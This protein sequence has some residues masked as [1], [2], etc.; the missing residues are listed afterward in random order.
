MKRKSEALAELGVVA[1][2][3]GSDAHLR[4]TTK[5][6]LDDIEIELK[7]LLLVHEQREAVISMRS[8][9]VFAA[10]GAEMANQ[11]F[12]KMLELTGFG[13]AVA[14]EAGTGRYDAPLR[15][16]HRKHW[17]SGVGTSDTPEKDL[18]WMLINSAGMHHIKKSGL[19]SDVVGSLM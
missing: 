8:K 16:L 5:D 3:L 14:K 6:D 19:M 9:V 10:T 15:R 1:D 11:Q 12:G 2:A 4:Y 18:V 7:R 13:R 17:H